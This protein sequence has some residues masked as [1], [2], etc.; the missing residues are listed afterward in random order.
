MKLYRNYDNNRSSFGDTGVLASGPNPDNVAV[1]AAQRS[2]DEALT[3]MVVSKYLT[4][5]TPLIINVTNYTGSGAAQVWQLNASNVISRL[6]N[7][8]YSNGALQTTVPS[9]S[10]T[11]LVLPPSTALNLTSGAS[12]TDGQF[13]FWLSGEIGR[14]FI[15]QSSPDLLHWTPVNTN[16]FA[17]VS[18]HFLLPAGP[19]VQFYRAALTH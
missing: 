10:I 3:I 1:F 17:S 11:L 16:T 6:A 8:N 13:E 2:S 5:T 9:Q 14:N 12:R 15:L 4:G 7:L 19:R 18:A